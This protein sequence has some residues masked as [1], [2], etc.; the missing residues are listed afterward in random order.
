MIKWH[1]NGKSIVCRWRYRWRST[2]DWWHDMLEIL[3]WGGQ[4]RLHWVTCKCWH[5]CERGPGLREEENGEMNATVSKDDTLHQ[6]NDWSTT[7]LDIHVW[8]C[9]SFWSGMVWTLHSCRS[10]YCFHLSISATIDGWK[11][12]FILAQSFCLQLTNPTPSLQNPRAMGA[13]FKLLTCLVVTACARW[14]VTV[15]LVLFTFLQGKGSCLRGTRGNLYSAPIDFFSPVY[16]L[17]HILDVTGGFQVSKSE[18]NLRGWHWTED[19]SS[20]VIPELLTCHQADV[21]FL[22]WTCLLFFIFVPWMCV[23]ICWQHGSGWF[24]GLLLSKNDL[25]VPPCR[26]CE[27]PLHSSMRYRTWPETHVLWACGQQMCVWF[28][29]QHCDQHLHRS[30]CGISYALEANP[31]GGLVIQPHLVARPVELYTNFLDRSWNS[32]LSWMARLEQSTSRT[33]RRS[34]WGPMPMKGLAWQ[35]GHAQLSRQLPGRK[36]SRIKM[37]VA[38]YS[39]FS[40]LGFHKMGQHGNPGQKCMKLL[41]SRCFIVRIL[42]QWRCWFH[43]LIQ[44]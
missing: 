26:V 32:E 11:W 24:P 20:H 40:M 15:S 4:H 43:F 3:H 14:E 9:R 2:S 44:R 12:S 29:S 6:T 36:K 16:R 19:V 8:W 27:K 21:Q 10:V 37:W 39:N 35:S 13:M 42:L 38:I 18:R 1:T 28:H 17:A 5:P 41:K 30:I 31:G 23:E 7:T 33:H 25:W 22:C 34:S